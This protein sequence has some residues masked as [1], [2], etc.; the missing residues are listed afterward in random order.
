M[1]AQRKD[2]KLKQAIM[3]NFSTP[4]YNR[5]AIFRNDIEEVKIINKFINQGK[6]NQEDSTPDR[7]LL[8]H[9]PTQ[10]YQ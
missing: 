9:V 7:K 3:K 4:L 10:T 6:H 8:F 5:K 2:D 1:L